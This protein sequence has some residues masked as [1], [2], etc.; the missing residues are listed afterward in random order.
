M[1][2]YEKT[3][4]E[5]KVNTGIACQSV[6]D[7]KI[8]SMEGMHGTLAITFETDEGTTPDAV[9]GL[10]DRPVT[11]SLGDG[12][13][14]FA[15]ICTSAALE[16]AGGYKKVHVGAAT[17]SI[18][19]DRKPVKKT[20]QDPSKTLRGVAEEVCQAYGA[21]ITLDS[22]VPVKQVLSQDNETDWQF[23]K[24]IAAAQGKVL[25]TDILAD[26]IRIFMGETGF[27]E[28]DG[29]V[30]GEA[31][32]YGRDGAEL[33]SM[34][35]NTGSGEGYDVDM[36]SCE[37]GVLTLSA[38]DRAGRHVIRKGEITVRG[39]VI[40]NT[41]GYGYPDSVRPTVEASSQPGFS[42][43]ILQGRVTAVEGNEIQVQFD[44]DAGPGNA[45]WVP[46][47]SSISNNFY[48]M[49][50][51][52]DTVY[53]YYENNGKIVCL[54]SHHKN[55]G[56]PD[57]QKPEEKV[58]TSRD[59]MIRFGTMGITLSAT[60]ERTDNEDCNAVSIT[61]DEKDGITINSGREIIM[62]SG[63]NIVL[64]VNV[65]EDAGRMAESGQEKLNKRVEKGKEEFRGGGGYLR[66]IGEQY[67]GH[68]LEQLENGIKGNFIYG[69]VSG[70]MGKEEEETPD[71]EQFE[72]GVLTL[73][74]YEGLRLEVGDSSIVMG[75]DIHIYAE[76][77]QW[78]GYEQGSHQKEEV[79]LQDWW[80][81][82][83]DG[84]QLVLDI[85]GCFPVLG[86]V[87][88]LLN[89]GVSLLR[90]DV[91]GALM[92]AV[93]A[94][95][96]VGDAVG[97]AKIAGKAFK[98]SKKLKKMIAI[99]KGV[100]MMLQ[101]A[102]SIYQMR[103]GWANIIDM[104]KKGENPFTDPG[105]VSILINT[106]SSGVMFCRGAK[107]VSDA[108]GATG[109]I[110]KK[111]EGAKE[112]RK[113]RRA[114]KSKKKNKKGCGDPINVVTGS[115]TMDYTDLV[116]H[117]VLE[118][119]ELKRMYESIHTNEGL[120]LGS[121]WYL[122][123]ET[124]LT[125]EDMHVTVQK[126]DMH[127]EHFTLSDGA[128]ENDRNG[129]ESMALGECPQGYVLRDA[130]TG[131][132][133]V[134]DHDG[135]I[136]YTEDANGNRSM[137]EYEGDVLRKLTLACGMSLTFT[138]RDGKLAETADSMGR[139]LTYEY[140]RD[141]LTAV[142]F[143]NG[144][145][146][147]Y[148]Y[149]AD[150][151][152]HQATDQNGTTYVTTEYD[153]R[154]RAVRQSLPTGEEY[155]L[156]YDDRNHRNTFTNTKNGQRIIYEY[157][158]QRVPEKSIYDDGTYEEK[159]YD[160]WENCIYDRDCNGNETFREYDKRG[161][162][163]SET[164]PDGVTTTYVY[165]DNGWLTGKSD[166][167]GASETWEYD[168]KGNTLCHR[169]RTDG[170]EYAVTRYTYDNC[171]RVLTETNPAGNTTRFTYDGS[172]GGPSMKVL[173]EGE[174]VWYTYD[175]AGRL[176]FES[177]AEGEFSYGYNRS[178]DLTSRTDALGNTVRYSYD[179]LGNLTE[180]RPPMQA[181][182]GLHGI[183]YTYDALDRRTCEETPEG[184]RYVYEYGNEE[185]LTLSIHP[186]AEADGEKD[187]I[188]YDYDARDRRIRAHYP[189]GGTERYFHDAN[190]NL[191]K[192]VTPECYD[193][194]TD[195]GDGYT[196]TYDCMDRLTSIINPLGEQEAAYAYDHE[197][198]ITGYTDAGSGV[199]CIYTYNHAGW[200]TSVRKPVDMDG[201]D[202]SVR[203]SLVTYKYDASG[204]RTEDKRY[205]D[206][207]TEESAAGKT[208][209]IH[210]AYN[211][212][213]R[214][215][216]ITDDTGAC[217]EYT[218]NS[219]GLVGTEQTVLGEDCIQ[220]TRYFYDAAGNVTRRCV[221]LE[222]DAV[223]TGE[224]P[225]AVTEY[226]YNANGDIEK[227]TLP[228]GGEISCRYD[229]DSR[230]TE[231]CHDEKDGE[232]HSRTTYTY[233]HAG[234]MVSRT[235][236]EGNTVTYAY[237]LMDRE[238][239]RTSPDGGVSRKEYDLD[240][241]LAR[242]VLPLEHAG[243]GAFAQGYRYTY[244]KAG[245]RLQATAPGGILYEQNTYDAAGNVIRDID[246][247]AYGFDLSGRR[248]SV[249][250]PEGSSQ[251][252][253]YDASGNLTRT[254]DSMGYTTR[255]Q[256]DAWGRVTLVTRADGSHERYTYDHAGNILTATDGE[257]H[258][259]SYAYN[260]RGLLSSRTDAM[261]A[262]EHFRYDRE[263]NMVESTDRNGVRL[264]LTYNMYQSL[265]GRRSMD[266]GISEH[267]GY[268]PDGKLKYAIGGGMRY[269][270]TYDAMGRLAGKSAGGRSLVAYTYDVGGNRTGLT[271]LTGK[272]TEY[273]Y[274][275]ADRLRN[276]YDN[277]NC[278]ACYTYNPDGTVKALEIG[279]NSGEG[280]LYTEYSY[281]RDRNLTGLK[282][283]VRQGALN[284]KYG[285]LTDNHYSYDKAGN[286]VIK[287][288]LSG[289][290]R[291]SYDSLYQLTEAVYPNK[292]EQFTY[293]RAGNRLTRTAARE[294]GEA[295]REAYT[296]DNANRL[297]KR[298]IYN[299]TAGAQEIPETPEM[300]DRMYRYTYDRQ[301]NM[302]SD[303]D[304]T[305]QYDGMNR[306]KKINTKA[307]DIQK[308]HYDGEGL[309]AELEENG[310]LVSFLY[311]DGEAVL[312]DSEAAGI[313]RYIRGLGL[314]TSDSE[315]ARTYYHYASDDLGSI[316]HITDEE[317][318]VLNRYEYDAFGNFTVKEE[319]IPNR[320]AFTGE[321]YDPITSQYYLRARFYNPVIGRFLN[322]DTYYGDG[323][324]LYTYCQNNPVYYI[325]PSGHK[326]CKRKYERYKKLRKLGLT[327]EEAHDFMKRAN[328]VQG[329]AAKGQLGE[330]LMDTI[331][332]K[333]GYQQLPSK[334]KSNN[335]IDGV[336]VKYDSKGRIKELVVGEAK[337]GNSKLGMTSMGKQMDAQWIEG[338]VSK[339]RFL[340]A[341]KNVRAAGRELY[342]YLG[343]KNPSKSGNYTAA[344][345]RLRKSG[346][347]SIKYRQNAKGLYTFWK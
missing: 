237:D 292:R 211:R 17:T 220:E 290:T 309:R 111:L 182:A 302:L 229:N 82:A 198:R 127:L 65:P 150:G 335:G 95:P 291:Y 259:A 165:D 133:Y 267:F 123:I 93:A 323:L 248:T 129:D 334:L 76:Q 300:A 266:G 287:Q 171:G 64:G 14:L 299:M 184:N 56:H 318:N 108:T 242:E 313:T 286:C 147:C 249:T 6:L 275:Y 224:I 23:L 239:L 45:A 47:E 40:V 232:I 139:T 345:F 206:Y 173:P 112:K 110:K 273:E 268:Y 217:M 71:A 15:G 162:L 271:D 109:K 244:D 164:T 178:D 55:T 226:A 337:F 218:Y 200:L 187:G 117:D 254:T 311:S 301:G 100:Y 255:F 167:T 276:V 272:R 20:F 339:M 114:E 48:C 53:I 185:C 104:I 66:L 80:E 1:E 73:Y 39:G 176:M 113:Q 120:M 256:T 321:Q 261:G 156:Y 238:V 181:A 194:G 106:A 201:E 161:S 67:I 119:F 208:N 199:P 34:V 183:R 160:Q 154:G 124:R 209:T 215:I 91:S 333:N 331:M 213:N 9:R 262:S 175:E 221:R 252:F 312:E 74:G 258:T 78:L 295:V 236:T 3:I 314:L 126:P 179:L 97:V 121:K 148:T 250:T 186:N 303:G 99:A 297:T 280:V 27:R 341:D 310:K 7:M 31:V 319:T 69:I 190:G 324:N 322:E 342:N 282:T 54:G 195:D 233:D 152:V 260:C 189:D 296:Y 115:L 169:V 101:S 203:Y 63:G 19:M 83:L 60:R 170:E 193:A 4:G 11:V 157:G 87:P 338:N 158:R 68:K 18:K 231:E 43:N 72:T 149:T 278:L 332:K 33:A 90:G 210:Y 103:D 145:R 94:I 327:A 29:S 343:I 131:L 177:G 336:Y 279:G 98:A 305:Y 243:R 245:R 212:S 196:Y 61:M 274:D 247:A 116:L 225:Y 289:E 269:D 22:D 26:G 188:R 5:I 202:G 207:Q 25:F 235:D 35:A 294:H 330:E 2:K 241:R 153:R 347:I 320:F 38:G 326:V 49:P 223:Y 30:L 172:Y 214:L 230:M 10:K 81:T 257:G 89:A 284:G 253:A 135:R 32:G 174:T 263:G 306:L 12:T 219:V 28:E 13:R 44:T 216:K 346:N 168:A 228:G 88:D 86:A 192:R 159:R 141:L 163:L 304:N 329:N 142:T 288:T 317:G 57:M 281:D 140:D 265:T 222:G 325:D 59:K 42:S 283:L 307:G 50:D 128:W 144:G 137:Y 36:M 79:P 21:D 308:N 227:I 191:I 234:N 136:L 132:K 85:A 77:F 298:S 344:V 125:R 240:G 316:T 92:S 107:N 205:L 46:Y 285:L 134:Y 96:G 105:N 62:A 52:G 246:G 51:I 277:G 24:R 84:L 151:Y 340:G 16:T 146:I 118:D 102:Y 197:G 293:D 58:L 328:N 41:V 270:Y 155:V 37:T 138:F 130:S 264:T 251:T 180:I 8:T 204:N 143:P 75:G 315:S 166:T 70:M 122:N